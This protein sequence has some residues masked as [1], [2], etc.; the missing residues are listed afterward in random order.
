MKAP[1]E[2]NIGTGKCLKLLKAVY[3][4]GDAPRKWYEAVKKLLL[5]Y[6][7]IVHKYDQGLFLLY[8]KSGYLCGFI[9]HMLMAVK[10]FCI[11]DPEMGPTLGLLAARIL[12][13][14]LDHIQPTTLTK[15][16]SSTFDRNASGFHHGSQ[17]PQ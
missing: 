11:C 1:P 6:D 9:L 5:K 15:Y 17:I 13:Y 10:I 7:L 12:R 16:P 14:S 4:L 8:D 3:G 2:M